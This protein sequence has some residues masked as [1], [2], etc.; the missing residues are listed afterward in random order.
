MSRSNASDD[1]EQ[2]R[3]YVI[4]QAISTID[5]ENVR[6]LFEQYTTWL[7]IDLS[8]QGYAAELSDLPGKYAPP[9][10]RLLLA[11]APNGEPYGCICLRPLLSLD[12]DTERGITK[13]CEMKRLYT[14]ESARGMGVGRALVEM[15]INEA[16]HEDYE[17]MRLDTLGDRMD[18]AI[19]LYESLGFCRIEPY[20]DTPMDETVFFELDLRNRLRS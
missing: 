20:Y 5:M 19:K 9:S 17:V 13:V 7:N 15:A 2:T 11:Q 4:K 16:R 6:L 3:Q 8:F 12:T 18:G 1:Q 14:T 10:G